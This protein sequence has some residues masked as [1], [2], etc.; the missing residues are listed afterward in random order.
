V[1]KY[2]IAAALLAVASVADARVDYAIDLTSPEHHT[3]TVTAVFPES[4]GPYLDVRMPAWRTGR[5]TIMNLANGVS[6]FTAT[7]S[8]GNPLPFEKVDKSTWRVRLNR[9]TSVHVRYELY[10][11]ELGS[12]SRHIDD[13][14]AYLDASAVFMYSDRYRSD[15]VSVSLNVPS[16]WRS[17]SGMDSPTSNR[18]VAANWD[19]LVDS[20]IETGNEKAVSFSEGGRDYQLV[21][22]GEGNYDINRMAADLKKIVAQ[23][24]HI[25]DS[26]PFRRYVFM[27][28]ATDNVGGATEHRNST[29]IQF[30]RY[31]FG[32]GGRY[33][34]FLSTAAH[35]FIHT[36]NVKAYRNAAMVPYDYEKENYTDLLWLEEGSTEYFTDP[37]LIWAGLLKPQDYFDQ[38]AG[39]I[40]A[41]R[42]RPGRLVQS[43]AGASWDEWISP[44]DRER[45]MN[46]WVNIYSEGQIASWALDIAL[47]QDTGG[48]V[49]YRDVHA[50]LYKRYK[51]SEKG[52]TDADILGILQELTGHSW[53]DWWAK[54]IESPIDPDFEAMLAPVGLKLVYPAS[55]SPK[56]WAGWR[57]SEAD[58]AMHVDAVQKGSPAWNAG[59]S[60]DDVIVA[61]DGQRMTDSRFKSILAEHKPGDEVKVT[62]FRR[63]Q[64]M[65]KTLKLG[66][67]N[68]PPKV[69]PVDTPT[70][71]QKALFQRWLLVPY[72]A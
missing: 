58:G 18:F 34:A 19:I 23:A 50:L 52:F 10:A 24:P 68:G 32:P 51:S 45:S 56:A 53:K 63:D 8:T 1:R 61:I 11:N 60:S 12:R 9:P 2:L 26:Y 44:S 33:E 41:N 40:D 72:P 54:H 47:L 28:H 14:H 13:S 65:E 62:F 4:S 42:N 22:W 31:L 48:R 6:Q 5:Y 64:L 66:S 43:V 57:A 38:L 35:E 46:A 55:A 16:G 7:D 20:P 59:F 36:W 69:V 3:G 67:N 29:V 15:D 21:V 70:A 49:S 27:V 30:P 37:F 71:A 39:A 17:F 25:W